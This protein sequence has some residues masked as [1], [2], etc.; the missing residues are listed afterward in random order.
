MDNISEDPNHIIMIDDGRGSQVHIP[1]LLINFEDGQE[2]LNSLSS[3]R[4]VVVSVSFDIVVREK[5]ELTLWLDITDHK[6]FIFLR[7]LRPYYNKIKEHGNSPPIQWTSPSP[8]QLSTV[9]VVLRQTAFSITPTAAMTSD[10][11]ESRIKDN[12]S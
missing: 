1:T 12:S 7:N 6:N 11:M 4:P 3:G 10:T 5:A 8:I 9:L 2:I